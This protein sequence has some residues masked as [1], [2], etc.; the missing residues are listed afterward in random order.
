MGGQV[1]ESRVQLDRI[2]RPLDRSLW[3]MTPQTVNAYY[4]PAMNEIVFPAGILR[5]PFYDQHAS[6]AENYGAI[7]MVMGHELT[8]G[9]DDQ[10]R[11]YDSLGNLREWWSPTVAAE[12]TRRASCVVDQYSAFPVQDLHVNGELTLGENL[13]DNGGIK[14][15][16]IALG[17]ALGHAPT[18]AESQAFFLSFAQSWCA[19]VQP[20]TERARVMTDPHSPPMFRV[21]GP[22]SNLPAFAEA[23]HCDAGAVMAPTDRCGVW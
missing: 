7:G 19:K 1:F 18:E 10:G 14:L 22:L 5:A 3:L 15:A 23:F 17:N 9:F 4:N 8:H 16:Y 12:F 21:N 6:T 20:A 11:Q 2:G 13:A